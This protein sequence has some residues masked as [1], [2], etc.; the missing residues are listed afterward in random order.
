M[1]RL[2]Q[3]G[4]NTFFYRPI[5]PLRHNILLRSVPNSVLPLDAMIRCRTPQ[6]PL[7]MYSPALIIMRSRSPSFNGQ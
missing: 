3:H 5:G 1:P 7:D 4:D 2:V 6:T